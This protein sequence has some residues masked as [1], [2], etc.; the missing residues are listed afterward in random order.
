MQACRAP[1]V[2]AVH[3]NVGGAGLGLVAS[4]DVAVAARTVRFR[5]AYI[6]LGLTPDASLT[7][8]LAD[9][10]GPV[11]TLD[12]LMTDGELT[13][14]EAR[15]AGLISRVA[16][17]LDAEISTLVATLSD[18]P[19]E[20]YARLKALVHGAAQRSLAEQL[21]REATAIAGSVRSVNGREGIA[22]FTQRRKPRFGT[23]VNDLEDERPTGTA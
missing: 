17:D 23:G 9:Q 15:S 13:A 2:A 4:C 8:R 10:L 5:P 22:A 1:I 18:G 12:L 11:R 21:D 14:A 20:A 3:G 16:D 6:A 7:W 19:L